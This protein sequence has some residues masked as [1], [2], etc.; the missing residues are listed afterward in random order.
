M[1]SPTS[2]HSKKTTNKKQTKKQN[3]KIN[4]NNAVS[5]IDYE[6]EK[7]EY[8]SIELRSVSQQWNKH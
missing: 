2:K 1:K 8:L 6:D 3:K 5:L 7:V 4:N